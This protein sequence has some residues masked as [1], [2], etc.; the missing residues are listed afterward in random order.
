MPQLN[1]TLSFRVT[2]SSISQKWILCCGK[3]ALDHCTCSFCRCVFGRGLVLEPTTV[4][5]LFCPCLWPLY[6]FTMWIFLF[7]EPLSRLP[8]SLAYHRHYF[9]LAFCGV[10]WPF[11]NTS[12][13]CQL[14][15]ANNSWLLMSLTASG[16][17][18]LKSIKILLVILIK[19]SDAFLLLNLL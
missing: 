10:F 9:L 11:H 6:T 13:L 15:A 5:L 4:H 3:S 14:S 19:V 18:C 2:N 12:E 17:T 8:P 1:I 16:W 7:P